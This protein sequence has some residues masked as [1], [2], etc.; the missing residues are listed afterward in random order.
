MPLG[1]VPGDL[2]QEMGPKD[3][4]GEDEPATPLRGEACSPW[5]IS[6][7]DEPCTTALYRYDYAAFGFNCGKLLWAE[8]TEPGAATVEDV[9]VGDPLSAVEPAY[10]G[11][12]CGAA[13]GGE[14]EEYPACSLQVAPGRFVWFGG[15]PIA[16]ITIGVLELE[17]VC[18]EKPFAGEVFE[19]EAGQFATYPPGEAEPG[20]KI[21]CRIDGKKIEEY[22]PP[23][24]TGVSTDPMYVSTKPDGSVRA[25]CGGIH[26]ENRTARELVERVWGGARAPP[27]RHSG[28]GRTSP[29]VAAHRL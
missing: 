29:L 19:L 1:G 25:E 14:W 24:N 22:V 21:L 3:P 12:V 5:S 28:A 10:P 17:G 18:R 4:A 15:D 27:P 16:T 9:A 23:P 20:D 2:H 6:Y 13:G 26:A 8:T 7:G 11:A